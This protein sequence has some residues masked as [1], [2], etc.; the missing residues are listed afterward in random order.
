MRANFGQSSPFCK[1][2]GCNTLHFKFTWRM[3]VSDVQLL[4]G[5]QLQL[6]ELLHSTGSVTRT[7]EKLGQ[8]QPTVSIWLARLREQMGDLLF[9][10][11]AQGMLPTPRVE[12]L[13]D[14]VRTVLAGLRSINGSALVFDPS[15][16]QRS[17]RIFM[18]DAS[19]T[20]LL[21]P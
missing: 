1:S 11:P 10:R 18:T 5:R 15:T 13:I 4:D 16:V 19:H 20:T 9:V 3:T 7:A 2:H 6:I 8:T 14:P 21:P 12:E 17:F